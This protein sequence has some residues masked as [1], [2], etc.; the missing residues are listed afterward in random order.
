MPPSAQKPLGGG[1]FTLAAAALVLLLAAPGVGVGEGT[2]PSPAIG[3][4]LDRLD[5]R[6]LQGPLDGLRTL[7]YE[8]CIPAGD[9]YRAR[10]T[11]IDPSARFL[12]GSPGRIG[13]RSDQVLV[14]GNTYQPRYRAILEALSELPFV[15]HIGE[16]LFE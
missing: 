4:D 11:A 10:V 16:C 12:R 1:R 8:Y 14:L 7:D 6:G 9:D 2:A 5:E 13:C 3:F 15:A